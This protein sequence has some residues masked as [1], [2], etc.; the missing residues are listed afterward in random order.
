MAAWGWAR[1]SAPGPC[2]TIRPP[3]STI[4][5]WQKPLAT[6]RSWVT[7]SRPRPRRCCSSL[8]RLSTSVCTSASSMLTLSSQS[9]TF[10]SRIRAR[11][12]ATRCCWPPESWRGRR[13]SKLS[14]GSRPTAA[15][16]ARARSRA[17]AWLARPW[18][19]SGSATASPTVIWGLRQASGSWN[20]IWMRRRARRSSAPFRLRRSRPSSRTDPPRTGARPIRARQR[21]LLPQPEAPTR[22]T[23][24]P[25]W[26][27]RLTPSTALSQRGCQGGEGRGCQLRS[28]SISSTSG[29]SGI[30]SATPPSR[31]RA[32]PTSRWARGERGVV[33]RVWL[34]ASSTSRPPS[35]TAIRS[36]QRP[37]MARSWLI[38]NRALPDSSH[39]PASSAIT[40]PATATSRLVVGSSAITRGGLR[41]RARAI[42][43]RWRMPP[44]NSWG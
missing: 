7:N 18:I 33:S 44:L 23:V 19:S 13:R 16:R 29:R 42:A 8:S 15:N 5:L 36:H 34:G 39:R 24:S 30:A 40:W 14:G 12:M 1:R 10:G 21:L 41:A 28:S 27:L 20:T 32:A 31:R 38:S 35:S 22:P 4:T 37:A 2:S 25:S 17:S 43:R 9:S 26:R 6:L 3:S 11:A